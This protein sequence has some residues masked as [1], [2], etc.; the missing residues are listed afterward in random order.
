MGQRSSGAG[1]FAVPS[2]HVYNQSASTIEPCVS[3]LIMPGM[4]DVL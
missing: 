4:I 2:R 3:H 1:S